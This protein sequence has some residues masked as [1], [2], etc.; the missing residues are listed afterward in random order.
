MPSAPAPLP[1]A[2][3]RRL[4]AELRGW[5]RWGP[6]D[7]LGTLNFIDA[8]RRAAALR[9]ATGERII[10]L[11]H[12]LSAVAGRTNPHP[13]AHGTIPGP[14]QQLADGSRVG[15]HTEVL[16]MR[17]HGQAITHLDALCHFSFEG[18][19]YNGRR[20][21]E[22]PMP[23][24]G[25][26]AAMR[27]GVV[28]RGVLLDVPR[29]LGA[30]WLEP[31]TAVTAELAEHTTSAQGVRIETG[32]VLLIRTGKRAREEQVGPWSTVESLAGCDPRLLLWLR[33]RE[34]AMLG[35]D[36]ISDTYPSPVPG[37]RTPVHT[38]ALVAM[39]MPLIDNC[40][41]EALAAGCAARSCWSF[42]F[43]LAPLHYAGGSSSP[44]NPLAV[45]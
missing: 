21:A 33:D 40:A 11:A 4:F 39:G 37:L 12:P 17:V 23:V 13:I 34:V 22:T 7:E 29:A 31:G 43:V 16:G 2:E 36:G 32:D 10:G 45:F 27:E 42:L 25:T 28:G 15:T 3:F 19:T 44:V 8:P 18:Q 1:L 5:G 38:I 30:A 14:D 35:S 20:V 6:D 41:L 24:H 26:I 9:A